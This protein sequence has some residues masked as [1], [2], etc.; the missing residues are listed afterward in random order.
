MPK[1]SHGKKANTRKLLTKKERNTN[2][3]SKVLQKFE[4]GES[5]F[6]SIEPSIEKGMPF[7]RF[8]GLQGTIIGQQGRCYLVKVKCGRSKVKTVL[9]NPAHLK[10]L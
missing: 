10:R 2:L 8:H 5:V 1:M 4:E 7:R 3:V 6:I 9:A